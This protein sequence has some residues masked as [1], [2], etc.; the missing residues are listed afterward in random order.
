MACRKFSDSTCKSANSALFLTLFHSVTVPSSRLLDIPS[1]YSRYWCTELLGD[2]T[3]CYWLQGLVCHL[4]VPDMTYSVF[5]GMLN[6]TQSMYLCMSVSASLMWPFHTLTDSKMHAVLETFQG[7]WSPRTRTR[8]CK[9]VL[10][11]KDFLK[12]NNTEQNDTFDS[13][14]MTCLSL[15]DI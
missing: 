3:K 10:D 4:S 7:F 1:V 15:R 9:L 6:P 12:D 8:T 5:S 14:N 11:D 2:L 13:W